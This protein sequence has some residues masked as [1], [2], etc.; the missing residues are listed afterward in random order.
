MATYDTKTL[1]LLREVLDE[2]W[3][4]LPEGSKYETLKSE[5]A[6][7]ILKKAADGERDPVRLRAFALVRSVGDHPHQKPR[8]A[9]QGDHGPRRP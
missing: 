4:A 9:L 8:P 5:M 1:H 3:G 7:R 2:A 6:L